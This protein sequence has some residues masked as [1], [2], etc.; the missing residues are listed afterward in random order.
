MKVS[1]Q[2]LFNIIGK[3]K[4]KFND[5]PARLYWNSPKGSKEVTF[6]EKRIIAIV[7]AISME[8]RLDIEVDYDNKL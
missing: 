6:E 5:Q 8:L 4:S 2:Q 3:A 7:E 1:S